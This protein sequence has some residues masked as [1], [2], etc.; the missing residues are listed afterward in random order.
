MAKNMNIGTSSSKVDLILTGDKLDVKNTDKIL[1][2]EGEMYGTSLPT[3]GE[4]G[5]IFFKLI[6]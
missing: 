6:E 3:T 1:L 2:N 5:Q 4:V